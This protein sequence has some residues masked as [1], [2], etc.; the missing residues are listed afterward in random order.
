[1]SATIRESWFSTA[2][3]RSDNW[4][5]VVSSDDSPTVVIGGAV[6]GGLG[7]DFATTAPSKS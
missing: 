6:G 3:S 2:R 4:L 1:M 5:M 7:L